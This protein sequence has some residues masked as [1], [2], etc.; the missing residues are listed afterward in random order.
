MLGIT[1][2]KLSKPIHEIPVN[3]WETALDQI[4]RK[5]VGGHTS[6]LAIVSNTKRGKNDDKEG[7]VSEET[8]FLFKRESDTGFISIKQADHQAILSIDKDI[9]NG[10]F[11]TYLK[12]DESKKFDFSHIGE[13]NGLEKDFMIYPLHK[14]LEKKAFIVFEFPLEQAITKMVSQEILVLFAGKYSK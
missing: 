3:E 10:I 7:S 11:T 2:K 9:F 14:G 1:S 8:S 13:K 4:Y 6:A 5:V 12:L